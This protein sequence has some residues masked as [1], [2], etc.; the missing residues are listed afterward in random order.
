MSSENAFTSEESPPDE[1]RIEQFLQ[2]NYAHL[3]PIRQFILDTY[4]ETVEEWKYY[5]VK[6]GWLLKKYYKKRNLFFISIYNGYFKIS[7]AFGEKAV[8]A[9]SGSAISQELKTQL[10][11][12][13]KYAE[14]RG[15]TIK[16]DDS[17]YLENLK[18]LQPLVDI[19]TK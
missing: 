17:G 5:G 3:E 8:H 9:I 4:G 16:V 11:P 14:G 13:R 10:D 18:P 6:N 15:L 1:K 2:S 12:A 7:F 19:L